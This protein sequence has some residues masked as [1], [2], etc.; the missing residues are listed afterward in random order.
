M[1]TWR[2]EANSVHYAAIRPSPAS[3]RRSIATQSGARS[4]GRQRNTSYSAAATRSDGLA[5]LL[6][7][8]E[9]RL[10][11]ELVQQSRNNQKAD[12]LGNEQRKVNAERV[13]SGRSKIGQSAAFRCN[14]KIIHT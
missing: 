7:N 10:V 6:Q 4:T 1:G 2:G 9:N 12:A 13:G 8:V 5:A 3:E 14:V 11:G